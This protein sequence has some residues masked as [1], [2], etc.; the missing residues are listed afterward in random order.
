MSEYPVPEDLKDLYVSAKKLG[1]CNVG[2][3]SDGFIADLIE[4]IAYLESILSELRRG[5]KE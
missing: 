4:R 1:R 2:T 3:W 5:V